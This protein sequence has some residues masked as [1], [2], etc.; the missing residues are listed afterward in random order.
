MRVFLKNKTAV[1]VF[2]SLVITAAIVYFTWFNQDLRRQGETDKT[3]S[4]LEVP[5]LY[6]ELNWS[7]ISDIEFE[8]A[9]IIDNVDFV[10]DKKNVVQKY[11]NLWG[12]EYTS[13][14]IFEKGVPFEEKITNKV[15]EYFQNEFSKKGFQQTIDIQDYKITL[16]GL[17]ADSLGHSTIGLV[18]YNAGEIRV[19]IFQ[20]GLMVNPGCE[21]KNI[22]IWNIDNYP[23]CYFGDQFK[24]F[25]SNVVNIKD[26]LPKQFLSF[27][28][29]E[30]LREDDVANYEI[31]KKEKEVSVANIVILDK[32]NNQ[33]KHRFQIELPIPDH[34]HP[35]E[36]HKCGVYA[37]K[38]FNYDYANRKAMPDYRIE[39]WRYGYNGSG[40]SV[41]FLSGPISGS[42]FG[43]DFRIDLLEKYI[44]LE[45]GYLGK[46]DYALII[47]DLKTKEDVFTLLAK[48]LQKINPRFIGVFDLLQWTDD[49]RYFW[50]SISDGA[51]VNGY[52][53]ID[54][55]SWKVDIYEAPQDVLGG[56]ALNVEK[57]YITVHPGNVW[58]GFADMTEEEKAK[59][60]VQGIGTELYIHNLF[61]GERQ[62]IDKTTEPLWY[63]KPQWLSDTELQY[64]LPTGEK[65]IYK[66]NEN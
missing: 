65:K 8:S 41:T 25:I 4:I 18:K 31:Q 27:I 9:F 19:I 7:Q 39:L 58:Y 1:L 54:T 23:G 16:R 33:E 28:Y 42:G 50:G 44:V 26:I 12:D 10:K 43:T 3:L 36:I 60:R 46:D 29:D 15:N 63:F 62:F 22:N 53:R 5:E 47:K 49:S 40:A 37:T 55:S 56:D 45:R 21:I 6:S 52:F 48:D 11:I 30:C 2:L 17:A 57:G 64:E 13:Q 61:T 34:Y 32:N 51:Y 24:L 66:I 59:R 20:E 14:P 38:S 35:I